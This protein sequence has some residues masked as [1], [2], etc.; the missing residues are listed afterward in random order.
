MNKQIKTVHGQR[1]SEIDRGVNKL[2]AE[3]WRL[4]ETSTVVTTFR[5]DGTNFQ[6]ERCLVPEF[7]V[8]LVKDGEP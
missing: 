5:P 2:L 7:V 1:A 8:K 6:I 4:L 3:G